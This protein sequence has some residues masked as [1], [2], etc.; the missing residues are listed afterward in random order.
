MTKINQADNTLK[1]N[2]WVKKFDADEPRLSEMV[3]LYESIGFEVKLEPVN[4]QTSKEQCNVCL[5]NT[6]KKIMTIY[7]KPKVDTSDT[8]EM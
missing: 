4:T 6:E 5:T 2:G 1:H 3:E 8:S 7:V